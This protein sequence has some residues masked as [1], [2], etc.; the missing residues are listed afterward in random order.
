MTEK[1]I[2]KS[3]NKHSVKPIVA[4]A[5]LIPV[6][7]ALDGYFFASDLLSPTLIIIVAMGASMY[8][9]QKVLVDL[10]IT[11]KDSDR[12]HNQTEA[13]PKQQ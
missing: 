3:I 4:L 10:L 13:S 1:D 12:A 8:I 5:L 9:F 6:L 7:K 2:A 11:G